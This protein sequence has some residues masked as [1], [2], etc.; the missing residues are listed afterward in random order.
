M[1]YRREIDGLR[2]VAVLPV[3]FFHAGLDIFAGGFVGVDVFFVIS[4]FLITTIII[5]QRARGRFSILEF[6]ERRARRILPALFLVLGASFP[7]AWAW[8]PPD[9]FDDYLRS[10]G[11]AAIFL[12]NVHFW[13]Y[14]DYFAQSAE[15][16]P[17]LHTWSLAVEEQYYLFFP[18]LIALL[19]VFSRRK[20][21]LVI[22]GIA[23]L[24][25]ALSEWGWR[26]HPDENFFFTFSRV[27]E[28]FA[29]SICA[30]IA[31]RAPPRKNQ[32][33]ALVGLAMILYAVF[34]Y[35]S[36]VP[37]PSLYAVV[38][39]LGT[40]L[41]LLY[42]QADTWVGRCLSMRLP[43]AIGLISYSAYLWHQPLF[44]FAR[45]R[46]L[47]EPALWVMLVLSVVTLGLAAISWRYVEQ[48]F[49]AG[50]MPLF[51]H[52]SQVFI[53][54]IAGL[55]LFVS[56]GLGGRAASLEAR[57]EKVVPNHI[58]YA[59][60]D[61]NDHAQCLPIPA[62]FSAAVAREQC[63]I[64]TG[65]P[66]KVV[67]LGDS[68]ADH[69]AAALRLGAK[70]IGY[71]FYQFTANSCIPFDGFQGFGRD[72]DTYAREMRGML[73]KL[74]PDVI[75]LSNRW[76]LYFEGERFS[77]EEGGVE[78]GQGAGYDVDGLAV[79]GAAY[80]QALTDKIRQSLQPFLKKSNVVLVYP[81]PE[82]GWNVPKIL[83]H[84]IAYDGANPDDLILTTSYDVF[85]ARNASTI[86]YLDQI[87]GPDIFRAYPHKALCDTLIP[88]RCLNAVP[89]KALYYDDD[90]LSNTGAE[91][92]APQLLEA[93]AKA[94]HAEK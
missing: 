93:V 32:F 11:F 36:S 81:N 19:G 22:G 59:F 94:L 30:F 56:V 8:M 75:V 91:F 55:F 47:H 83:Q 60:D 51:P 44:A 79:G 54:S 61:R 16:R 27:W 20:Y 64:E 88:G 80:K 52:R 62:E 42:A 49:R 70:D 89:G 43:V 69:Y 82:A 21:L 14:S 33:L 78:F 34:F 66:Q 18:Y 67:L 74:Q 65:A 90:H 28:L 4:G 38:P 3:I 7:L 92:I 6:Y 12:S 17:L 29:G 72:C 9:G 48:P 86:S 57:F 24:S 31:F 63:S 40:S 76:T 23:I 26:N 2:A 41:V 84:M 68:H 13:E 10:L 71:D 46:S 15:L 5:D 73:E 45:I 53:A 85:R 35:D 58:L 39:V 50:K 1:K 77:N 25:L 37:F 87:A